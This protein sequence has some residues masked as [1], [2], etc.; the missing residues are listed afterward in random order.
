MLIDVVRLVIGVMLMAFHR[1]I[2][3][4]CAEFDHVFAAAVRARGLHLPGPP[5]PSVLH[6][7]Y[8]CLGIGVSLFAMA[9]LYD[10]LPQ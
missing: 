8:F 2:A 10:S 6:T 5:R 1:P 7:V 9:R 4:F 3:D